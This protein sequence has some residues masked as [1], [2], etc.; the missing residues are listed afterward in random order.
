MV[1]QPVRFR[2]L[3]STSTRA[4]VAVWS[5]LVV[6]APGAA[7]ART[8]WRTVTLDLE[9]VDGRWLVDAWESTPGPTPMASPEWSSP[10]RKK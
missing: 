2:T 1:E 7:T 10:R 6:A 4:S 3:S 8:I 5:V 9:L